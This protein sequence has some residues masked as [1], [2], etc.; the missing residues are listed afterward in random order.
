MPW[1]ILFSI[2]L[3]IQ[4]LYWVR[5]HDILAVRGRGLRL[6]SKRPQAKEARI[7]IL[8]AYSAANEDGQPSMLCAVMWCHKTAYCGDLQC[9]GCNC[10]STHIQ[11]VLTIICQKKKILW[12]SVRIKV[13]TFKFNDDS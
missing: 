4:P 7:G 8:K 11:T 9:I 3:H 12:S 5:L 6:T 10:N 2:V 13:P 1:C